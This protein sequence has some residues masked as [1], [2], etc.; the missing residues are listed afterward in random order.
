MTA[1][2]RLNC[3][4]AIGQNGLAYSGLWQVRSK[5]SDLY[6]FASAIGGEIKA[7]VHAPRPPKYPKWKR[8]LGIPKEASSEVAVRIKSDN[9]RHITS[10]PGYVLSN[11]ATIEWRI[12]FRGSSLRTKPFSVPGKVALLPVPKMNEQVEVVVIIAPPDVGKLPPP[13]CLLAQ[14]SLANG[15]AVWLLAALTQNS[16]SAGN[17][18]VALPTPQKKNPLVKHRS[19]GN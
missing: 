7:S 11:G 14:G 6:C 10:W 15:Y 3:K 1:H 9:G 4:F 13:G 2:G 17:H 5:K 12:F 16:G 8:H 19:D 18:P